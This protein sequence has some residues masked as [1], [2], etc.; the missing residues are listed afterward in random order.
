MTLVIEKS[1][2]TQ[3]QLTHE[4]YTLLFDNTLT[5]ARYDEII[6]HSIRLGL[7]ADTLL[8]MIWQGQPAWREKHIKCLN[9]ETV[10]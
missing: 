8:G 2:T 10:I 1:E 6:D 7:M 3:N 4:F 9:I 5:Q